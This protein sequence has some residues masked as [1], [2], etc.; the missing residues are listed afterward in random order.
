MEGRGERKEEEEKGKRKRRKGVRREGGETCEDVGGDA[1]SR[2]MQPVR[3]F[4]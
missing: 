3:S 4:R 1:V 2:Q